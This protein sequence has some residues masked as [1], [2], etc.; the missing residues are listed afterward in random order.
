MNESYDWHNEQE[1]ANPEDSVF[2]LSASS[3]KTHANCPYRFHLSKI[4][5]LPGT[6]ADKGFLDLGSAVH[7]SIENTLEQDRWAEGPRPQNQLRQEL[8]SEFRQWDPDVDEDL[9]DRGM[10]CLEVAARYLSEAQGGVDVR[11][12]EERFEFSL[13]RPDISAKFSGYIDVITENGEVWDWKTGSVREEGE[14]IQGAVYMRGYQELYGEP[15]DKIRFI[16]LKEEKERALEPNDENWQE[17]IDHA[18]QCVQDIKRDEFEAKP[19]DFCY[20]CDQEGFCEYSPV[21][22][23]NV[24]FM[25]Y[26]QRRARF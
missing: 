15:P 10:N 2:R 18:R 25:N 4:R 24:D 5:D 16:Y 7:E 12:L 13:G 22:A 20:W 21:G 14:I 17:M 26:R 6:K 3:V 9:W 23:G 11:S 19:G 8:I 1:L